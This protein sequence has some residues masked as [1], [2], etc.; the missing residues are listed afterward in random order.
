M[1]CIVCLFVLWRSAMK[2]SFSHWNFTARMGRSCCF[3]FQTVWLFIR[4]SDSS[5]ISNFHLNPRTC[6]A[7]RWFNAGFHITSVLCYPCYM[8]KPWITMVIH[9]YPASV[10]GMCPWWVFPWSVHGYVTWTDH[11]YSP[12]HGLT[13]II[14]D[15]DTWSTME[16]HI[17][18]FIHA[19][20]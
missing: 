17:S 9:G 4:G 14:H 8:D 16:R 15:H 2:R 12:I 20:P 19:K 10:S 13:M 11:V 5:Q 7:F 1:Y 6:V 3:L 18:S